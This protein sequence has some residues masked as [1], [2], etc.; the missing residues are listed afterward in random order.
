[1]SEE[2][3]EQREPTP[4]NPLCPIC[5]AA[6]WVSDPRWDHALPTSYADTTQLIETGGKVHHIPL[7]W[8]VCR[9]CRFVRL[10]S[11]AGDLEFRF[12]G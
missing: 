5:G 2:E 6:D 10:H 7:K 8:F 12:P 3:T 9:V 1:M 11:A 4:H